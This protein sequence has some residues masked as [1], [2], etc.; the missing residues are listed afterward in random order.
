[1]ERFHQRGRTRS[2]YK[3][4]ALDSV[5][6][7]GNEQVYM[8]SASSPFQEKLFSPEESVDYSS[9]QLEPKGPLHVQSTSSDS[10]SS[11]SSSS[12]IHLIATRN[13]N[14]ASAKSYGRPK[15]LYLVR[16]QSRPSSRAQPQFTI[17]VKPSGMED[18]SGVKVRPSSSS[19]S[20][21]SSGRGRTRRLSRSSSSSSSS[22][23]SN[24]PSAPPTGQARTFSKSPVVIFQLEPID[25]ET[26]PR[27][28]SKSPGNKRRDRSLPPGPPPSG[29][30][31]SHHHR[32]RHGRRHRQQ[33]VRSNSPGAWKKQYGSPPPPSSPP[34]PPP[35][36]HHHLHCHCQE[37]AHH[38][39]QQMR[40]ISPIG[41]A[42]TEFE[43]C[44]HIESGGPS[45]KNNC[46]SSIVIRHVCEKCQRNL[47]RGKALVRRSSVHSSLSHG[48]R[49]DKSRR[50]TPSSG[51][52]SSP[53]QSDAQR[54][55]G[56][57]SPSPTRQKYNSQNCGVICEDVPIF[58]GSGEIY[59]NRAFMK[60]CRRSASACKNK[61]GPTFIVRSLSDLGEGL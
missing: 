35:H 54:R 42:A 53:S 27:K 59:A 48:S 12:S 32:S 30:P 19:S 15:Q 55:K 29:P 57:K 21:S 52:F 8:I 49:R 39:Q 16:D 50:R 28:K 7:S 46:Q 34:R 5:F 44:S 9:D 37:F 43:T 23:S 24:R 18:K 41:Q 31:P 3:M 38:Q 10:S 4:A 6:T 22:S 61:G 20:S 56:S 58:L 11:S 1:M 47:N 40:Q 25:L 26:K 33:R 45:K 14:E 2:R 17:V 13:S 36:H 60:S 51:R